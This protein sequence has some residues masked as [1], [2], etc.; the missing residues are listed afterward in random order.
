MRLLTVTEAAD[1]LRVRKARAYDLAREGVLPCV[2]LGRQ[3]RFDA[4][5]LE[6]WIARGGNPLPANQ[7]H[8]ANFN[9]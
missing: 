9:A 3:V 5:A 7:V 2:R 1:L 6:E 4:C 8:E